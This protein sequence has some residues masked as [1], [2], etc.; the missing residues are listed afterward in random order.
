MAAAPT[1]EGYALRATRCDWPLTPLDLAPLLSSA[2]DALLDTRLPPG[3][4]LRSLGADSPGGGLRV[5]A[6]AFGADENVTR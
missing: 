4:R 3:Q 2:E 6:L 5:G 1:S